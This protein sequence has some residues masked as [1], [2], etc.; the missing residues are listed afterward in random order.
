[1]GNSQAQIRYMTKLRFLVGL[2]KKITDMN[3]T[4]SLPPVIGE[5]GK[6]ATYATMY[7][8]L[9][10]AQEAECW[11]NDNGYVL[12][13]MPHIYA[14]M[15]LQSEINP[16]L[17]D[18]VRELAGGGLIQLPSSVEDLKNPEIRDT[19]TKYVQ[20]P[21][22][23]GED[24]IKLMKLAWDMIGSEFAGRHEQYEKFYAGA[25][26]IV[27]THAHRTYDWDRATGLV[28]YALSGY[29]INGRKTQ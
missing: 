8:G 10:Y 9:V 11:T 1:M 3:G 12:P 26:F 4:G 5:L 19:I 24:R 7:E 13:S 29:D 28:D 25:P 14:N 20:S 16:K 15:N 6:L 22:V 27:K 21:G 17:L 18:I 23:P 2:A